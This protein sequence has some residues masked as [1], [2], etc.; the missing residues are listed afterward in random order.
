MSL[1][2]VLVVALSISA[3]SAADVDDAIVADTADEIIADGDEGGSEEPAVEPDTA[4]FTAFSEQ[5]EAADEGAEI[6]LEEKT[7]DMGKGKLTITKNITIKGQGQGKTVI[8][9]DGT[10]QGDSGAFLILKGAG[11]TIKDITFNNL[12][13]KKNYGEEVKGFAIKCKPTTRL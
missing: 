11:I 10:G 8:N 1:L 4:D 7:Y 13:G 3:A 2:L 6:E 9:I 5:V 12:D